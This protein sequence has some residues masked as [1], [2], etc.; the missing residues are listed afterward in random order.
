MNA[1][2][3]SVRDWIVRA[4]QRFEGAGLCFGHGT[5]NAAD[6]AA[7]LVL[8]GLGLPPDLPAAAWDRRVS[9]EEAQR[10][11]KMVE[12]RVRDRVPAA[13]LNRRAWFA[14]LSFYVDERVLVPR[15]PIAELIADEFRPWVVPGAAER[16]LDLCTGCGCIG[17]AVA[18]AFPEARVD[19]ADLSEDALAV[20]RRNVDDHGLR[21]RVRV[22][23]SD[24]YQALGQE[25]DKNRYDLIVANPPYVGAAE[26]ASLP[27]EYGHEPSFGLAAGEDGLDVLLPL[28]AGAPDHMT[29]NG[30]LVVETGDTGETLAAALPALPFLWLEFRHGGHGVFLLHKQELM[31]HA[32]VVVELMEKRQERDGS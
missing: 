6:E 8:Q 2:S 3:E 17:I 16:I 15:S 19:L 12:T 11:T 4:Q 28:L 30:I 13:Y 25:M 22:I 5:D 14:G 18:H 10:L 21:Q 32:G 1:Q 31:D 24:L 27:P 23:A 9:G 7:G 26:L 29:E 20:A